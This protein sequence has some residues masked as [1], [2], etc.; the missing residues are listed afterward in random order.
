MSPMVKVFA[1]VLLAIPLSI[2]L[3]YLIYVTF[4]NTESGKKHMIF[5]L[6]VSIIGG[7]LVLDDNID[8]SG[9]EYSIVIL[10]LILS[11]IGMNKEKSSV[12]D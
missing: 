12:K 5:G 10:G 9:L 6:H 3:L 7:I 11:I 8:V 4:K 2:Y 1:L